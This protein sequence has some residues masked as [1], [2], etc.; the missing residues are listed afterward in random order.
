[1]SKE[2]LIVQLENLQR[3]LKSMS[4][5]S[6]RFYQAYAVLLDFWES[7]IEVDDY[8]PEKVQKEVQGKLNRLFLD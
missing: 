6:V 3:E 8:I 1:M 7:A 5:R 2:K 4:A